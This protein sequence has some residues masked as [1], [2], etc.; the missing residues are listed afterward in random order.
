MRFALVVLGG[1]PDHACARTALDFARAA[2]ASG[3]ELVRVFFQGA[4]VYCASALTVAPQDEQDVAAGW[5]ALGREHG[6]DLVVCVASA[7]KRG[8]LDDAEADRHD[9]G[10]GNLRPEFTIS[11]LGQ[12]VDASLKADRVVTFAP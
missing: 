9:R 2:L 7:L 6:L 8:L 1:P 10:R 12:L 11:G 3:H 5:A 4:G